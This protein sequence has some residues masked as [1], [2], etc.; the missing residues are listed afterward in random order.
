[1]TRLI[2][3]WF[4]CSEV[5]EASTSGW[6]SGN[7]EATLFTWFAKRPLAQAKAAV[8]TSLLPWPDVP[9]EQR[10]LQDL[11]RRALTG[12][13][14]GRQEIL[15]EL[16]KH[17][18][19]GAVVLDPFSGRGMI[20]LEAAR[21][22]CN[23]YGLDYSPVATVAGQ[24]LADFPL[25]NWTEEP[26]IPFGYPS[27]ALYEHR[28]FHDVEQTLNEVGR[29][30]NSAMAPFYPIVNGK[31]PWGYVWAVSLPCQECGR[32]FPMTGSL[33]LRNPNPG[34]GDPGQS[35]R[36]IADRQTGMVD[37]EVHEGPPIGS[38][39]RVLA[40]KSK[41]DASGK[42]AVCPFCEHVHPKDV[43]TRLASQGFGR[44][45]LLLAADIDDEF[46]KRY[47]ALTCEECEAAQRSGS[48]L[49]EEPPFSGGL[50]AVPAE[51]IPLGN[52]WTIQAS[53]Y[54]ARTYGDM[55]NARQTLGFVKIARIISD[56]GREFQ[57]AGMSSDYVRA[58][59]GYASSVMVR[60]L[61]RSTRGVTLQVSVQAVSDVFATESS[62]A[63]SYDYF[64]AGLGDGP[65]SWQ[66]IQ[67]GSLAA[68]RR[69][70]ERS[71]GRPARI[72][73]GSAISL[74]FRSAAMDAVVTDPP[75]DAMIDYTDA[76]D[77]SYVWLKRSMSTADPGLMMTSEPHGVQEKTEEIIVKK[78]GTSS[79][80]PR[81]RQHYDRL[82]AQAFAEAK[83]VIAGDG[84]VTIVFGHG[85]PEVWHRLLAAISSAGLVLTGSWPAKTEKGGKAGSANIVTTLTMSCRPAPTNRPSGRANI[86]EAEVRREVKNRVP[87]WEAAGLAP[88]DQLMASAGPAMEVVGRYSSVLDTLGEPVEPDRY[89]LVA[90][91]AVEEAAAVEIDN[92]ALETF[93]ARTRFALSW[94]RL[95]ARTI[96]PKSEARWQALASDL[97]MDALRGILTNVDKGVR[98]GTAN[99][100][101]G[102]VGPESVVIDVAI[103]MAAAWPEGLE[104]VGEVLAASQR[105]ADDS[106]LWA[107]M[108]FLS[109]KLPEADPD[110]IA[111]TALVRSRRVIKSVARD[112]VSAR[113][114]AAA[115]AE[116]RP[117]Q[118]SLFGVNE[119]DEG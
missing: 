60:K 51:P 106:H 11:V 69:Q 50:P 89:L 86:V 119:E 82:I 9:E 37:I 79:N 115:D 117:R 29:R 84:V 83:R 105:T 108:S 61:R 87:K 65:G 4:P 8:L 16:A 90:R 88:T 20:P 94:V 52:T 27:Q 17:Y 58:L 116:P 100:C 21:L 45:T 39:T 72:T 19:N 1:M 76:S 63:F 25:R 5:S 48:A 28:L 104:A 36:L 111:W 75:Y 30:F 55:C 59:C 47:R 98:F 41:F 74:P 35:Y 34:K 62:L 107:T 31:Y 32:Y 43:H 33:A 73:R 68:L 103:A 42:V 96:A 70:V 2:E 54:G 102:D 113:S 114:R 3:R 15:E 77:L 6:G 24:L 92:L 10:R 22:D 56:L 66:S 95:Y 67:T 110:A 81:T 38:P 18:P 53:V 49:A 97:A 26:S 14:A 13:Q 7:S 23:A 78:G 64:E 57:A 80:D 99:E 91:R 93:D 12:Y 109:S 44:D 71:G 112:V 40:G 46:G 118:T 101:A 85:E